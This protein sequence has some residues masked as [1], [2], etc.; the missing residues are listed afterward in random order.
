MNNSITFIGNWVYGERHGALLFAGSTY[1]GEP[2]LITVS[3]N[4]LNLSPPLSVTNDSPGAAASLQNCQQ[5]NVFG[6]TLVAGGHGVLFGTNCISASIL[7]NNFSGA[8][9][10]G[11]GYAT[12]GD[13]LT[14]AQIFGNTLTEGV[15]FHIQLPYSNSFGW[16]VGSNTYVTNISTQVPLFTDPAS[17]AIHLYN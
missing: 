16:F 1:V 15:S 4:W 7:N 13:F 11:I 8:A 5:A 6:N 3:G 12:M 10:R 9:Y 17:S 14:T 2:A